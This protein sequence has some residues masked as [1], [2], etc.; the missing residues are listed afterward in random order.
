[1][2]VVTK[3]PRCRGEALEIFKTHDYCSQCN[4]SSEFSDEAYQSA[5][6]LN[7]IIPEW[8]VAH[9]G[10]SEEELEEIREINLGKYAPGY[11]LI[12]D[13]KKKPVVHELTKDEPSKSPRK[14]TTAGTH[15]RN[16]AVSL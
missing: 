3:C 15:S 8:A 14:I 7:P 5:E 16:M 1:M 4:Y 12:V 2:T 10:L 11:E 13:T 6:T 9:M